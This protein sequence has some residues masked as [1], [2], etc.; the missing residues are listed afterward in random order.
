M[1]PRGPVVRLVIF[2]IQHYLVMDFFL[3]KFF[4]PKQTSTT[5]TTTTTLMGFDTIEI[6]LVLRYKG[7]FWKNLKQK[8]TKLKFWKFYFFQNILVLYINYNNDAHQQISKF[9]FSIFQL[10]LMINNLPWPCLTSF[11][12]SIWQWVSLVVWGVIQPFLCLSQRLSWLLR[13]GSD[14]I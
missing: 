12:K 7:L 10:T 4:G 2:W 9:Y 11:C 13:W 8:S 3:P 6:N 5:I 14:N 1:Y